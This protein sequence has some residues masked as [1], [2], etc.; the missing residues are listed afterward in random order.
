ME[1]GAVAHLGT[2]SSMRVL[3]ILP[4]GVVLLLLLFGCG[5]QTP[6]PAALPP[7]AATNRW[8]GELGAF[9][10]A[11]LAVPPPTR[12]IV[13]TGSSSFRMWTNLTSDFPGLGVINRGFGGSQLSDVRDHFERLILIYRPR[14]VLIYCGGNDLAAGKTVGRVVEDLKAVVERI[15]R[16]LPRTQVTYLSIALNPSRWDQRDKVIAANA[17]IQQFITGDPRRRFLDV[18][19]AML[20]PDGQPK[21]DIFMPDK[22][23]MNRKGYELWIPIIRP[24]LLR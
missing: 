15:H 6:H 10:A 12:P 18:T 21:P 11:D 19:T 17:A 22:L 23:H 16:E 9:A 2:V 20:G 5:C 24:A 7:L 8:A 3:K 1:L 13:F 4:S 14:Q